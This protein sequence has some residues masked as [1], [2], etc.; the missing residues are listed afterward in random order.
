MQDVHFWSAVVVMVVVLVPF[1]LVCALIISI[2]R[3]LNRKDRK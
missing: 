1:I 2:I 3:W